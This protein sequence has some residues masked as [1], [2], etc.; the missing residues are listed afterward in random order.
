MGPALCHAG[1]SG[2]GNDMMSQTAEIQCHLS[3]KDW[4]GLTKVGEGIAY[5]EVCYSVSADFGLGK[6]KQKN[7][8]EFMK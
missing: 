7:R 8:C 3:K 4:I 2:A 5:M 1:T 6:C